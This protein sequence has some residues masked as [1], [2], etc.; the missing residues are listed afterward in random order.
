MSGKGFRVAVATGFLALSLAASGCTS[1][2]PSAGPA[3][4]S[5]PPATGGHADGPAATRNPPTWLDHVV[6]IV[7]ENQPAS[8]IL[9]NKA[10][11]YI[12]KLAADHAVA[13]NYQA[14][15]HPSLPNYLALTSGTTAGIT[16]DCSPGAGC[17]ATVPNITEAIEHSGRTWKMY[18]ESMPAPCS[19]RNSGLYAVRHNPFMYYPDV[20]ENKASCAAHVVPLG[21]LARD[22]GSASRLPNYVFISPN[23]CHDMHD[24][25]VATGD[26]WLAHYVPKILASPAFT[27]RNSLLVLT[28]DEGRG[29]HNTVATI[30]AGSA[31][32]EGQ[33]S[34]VAYSHYSLLRTVEHLWNLPPMTDNDKQASVMTDMLRR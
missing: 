15:A 13:G 34:R 32:R 22:L 23:T 5:A 24:C 28:W 4:S 18:A 33:R 31:A 12:N 10:A 29:K 14:V 2:P 8:G 11:P 30:F 26:A 17:I 25:P 20:T 21:Q 3:P 9:G 1:P 27:T 19:G 6:I 7:E 16:D